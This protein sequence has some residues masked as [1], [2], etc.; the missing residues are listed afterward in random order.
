M[1]KSSKLSSAGKPLSRLALQAKQGTAAG[2]DGLLNE[3]LKHFAPEMA[4]TLLPLLLLK[5]MFRGTEAAGMKGGLSVWF[6]KGRGPKDTCESYGQILL[7]PC[8]AKLIHQAVRPPQPPCNSG[9][10]PAKV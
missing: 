4:S 5:L 6:H 8:F 9:A 1:H 3:L 10:G 7:L 2:I